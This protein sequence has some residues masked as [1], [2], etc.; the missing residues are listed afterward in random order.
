MLLLDYL[1]SPYGRGSIEW[2]TGRALCKKV[3]EVWT[4]SS[5]VE[6]GQSN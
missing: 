3:G 6:V 1:M 4:A 2:K 5:V